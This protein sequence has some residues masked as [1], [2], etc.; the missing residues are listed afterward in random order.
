MGVFLYT[1][2]GMLVVV[3][4]MEDTK[5]LC[6]C[7]LVFDLQG[8]IQLRFSKVNELPSNTDDPG[9]YL[10]EIIPCECAT[11][12]TSHSTFHHFKT[13]SCFVMGHSV[14]ILCLIVFLIRMF[15]KFDH[16]FRCYHISTGRT[17]VA[18]FSF[19]RVSYYGFYFL[20]Q[21]VSAKK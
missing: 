11:V 14:F 12:E 16:V 15:T 21:N 10:F 8:V 9:K 18:C 6:V 20:F 7:T 2:K 4:G 19:P 17:T 3:V 13:L 1:V 5:S